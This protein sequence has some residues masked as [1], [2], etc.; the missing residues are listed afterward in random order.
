MEAW[1]A[2][3]SQGRSDAAWDDLIGSY[4]RLIL[5]AI[6]HYVCDPDDMM[7]VFASVCEALRVGAGGR[8]RSRD[9]AGL[10]VSIGHVE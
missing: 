7:D 5:A 2:A 8:R 4:R 6:R 1:V 10:L 3:L 9:P